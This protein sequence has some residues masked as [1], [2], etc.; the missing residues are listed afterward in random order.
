MYL[1]S[2]RYVRASILLNWNLE[3][4]IAQLIRP[5]IFEKFRL[6]F[7]IPQSKLPQRTKINY[8]FLYHYDR[9]LVVIY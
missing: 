3:V 4:T 8:N 2:Q 9:D 7:I 5:Q 1:R 6:H